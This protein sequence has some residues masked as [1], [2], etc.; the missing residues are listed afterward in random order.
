MHMFNI[1]IQQNGLSS[2]GK[3]LVLQ[4]AFCRLVHADAKVVQTQHAR[5]VLWKQFVIISLEG[6]N[7]HTK[8]TQRYKKQTEMLKH[9][10]RVTVTLITAFLCLIKQTGPKR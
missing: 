7:S 9:R 2:Y 4:E 3:Y 10:R 8:V 6:V 5:P 1:M